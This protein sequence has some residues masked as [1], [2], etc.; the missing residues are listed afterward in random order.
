VTDEEKA[1]WNAKAPGNHTHDGLYQPKG[2]YQPAGNYAAEGHTHGGVYATV[3]QLAER[4]SVNQGVANVGKILVVGTD[5]KLT[6]TDMPEGGASGDVVG[7]LDES[8]N[9]LLS[10]NL[11]SG[12]YTLKYEHED[13]TYTDIGTL[14]VGAIPEPEVIVNY[15][16]ISTDSS[17]AVYNGMGYKSKVRLKSDG[18]T[19]STD[20]GTPANCVITGY[21]PAISGDVIRTKNITFGGSSTGYIS[22][23]FVYDVSFTKLKN[24]AYG[25]AFTPTEENGIYTFTVPNDVSGVAYIRVQ[26]QTLDDTSIVTVNQEIV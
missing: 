14:V 22:Q 13:G 26:A 7:T 4:L 8:N 16:P 1:A 6:L 20:I 24:Y 25:T 17:G 11:A 12:T 2:N 23:F 21:I 3:E 15:I 19:E 18:V 10:G 9:I 5:G